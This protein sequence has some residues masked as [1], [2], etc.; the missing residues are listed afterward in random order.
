M[1]ISSCAN[2]YLSHAVGGNVPPKSQ[3]PED[4]AKTLPGVKKTFKLLVRRVQALP[5]R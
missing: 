3:R 2:I 4:V 5:K 1:Q